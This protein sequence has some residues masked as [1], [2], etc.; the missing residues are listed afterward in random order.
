M[1]SGLK[2]ALMV[3][4][5][6]WGAAARAEAATDSVLLLGLHVENIEGYAPMFSAD[7]RPR[8]DGA[9][10]YR[11]L[12][13]HV[14]GGNVRLAS[15]L[16]Y[17]AVPQSRGFLYLGEV[18]VK[19]ELQPAKDAEP[20]TPHFYD[21]TVLWRA[22]QRATIPV[23]KNQRRQALER[24]GVAGTED[25]TQVIYVTSK[26]LCVSHTT[27]EWTGGA[28]AFQARQGV[29]LTTPAGAPLAWPLSRFADRSELEQFMHHALANY[30]EDDAPPPRL[31]E[32]YNAWWAVIDF[33]N[34]PGVCLQHRDGRLWLDGTVLLPGN[35]A[36]SFTVA[37]A[38]RPAPDALGGMAEPASLG[39]A[40]QILPHALDVI[41]SL[42]KDIWVIVEPASLVA[43]NRTTRRELLRLP[44][45][46]RIVMVEGARGAAVGRWLATLA[47]P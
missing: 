18:S 33:R 11:T 7:G 10:G 44:I 30:R 31:D 32:P 45:K 17:L 28:L 37:A 36:R 8:T 39:E 43:V 14:A 2:L 26:A 15:E 5:S 46:G 21:A 20:D 35:S 40:Q 3:L 12:V 19:R 6:L 38:V 4:V 16:S 29:E 41:A 27:S 9:P 47:A 24:G 23:V 13:L 42:S 25:T 1:R 22:W 34:D